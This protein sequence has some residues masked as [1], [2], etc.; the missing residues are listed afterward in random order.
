MNNNTLIKL[1]VGVPIWAAVAYAV[2]TGLMIIMG[3]LK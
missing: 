2:T 3:I 1:V